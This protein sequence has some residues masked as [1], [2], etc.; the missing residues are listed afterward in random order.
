VLSPCSTAVFGLVCHIHIGRRPLPYILRTEPICRTFSVLNRLFSLPRHILR[1]RETVLHVVP[2]SKC[3][4]A[5]CR[6]FFVG[7]AYA[8][9][10]PLLPTLHKYWFLWTEF[11]TY[12]WRISTLHSAS[13]PWSGFCELSGSVVTLWTGKWKPHRALS[14]INLDCATGS[15]TAYNFTRVFEHQS[16]FNPAFAA[17]DATAHVPTAP[18]SPLVSTASATSYFLNC[19]RLTLQ[20]TSSHALSRDPSPS[21]SILT[22]GRPSQTPLAHSFLRQTRSSTT[23]SDDFNTVWASRTFSGRLPHRPFE[24]FRHI[25]TFGRLLSQPSRF[26]WQFIFVRSL[27]SSPDMVYYGSVLISVSV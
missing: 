22:F 8:A 6:M 25:L 19:P 13:T 14:W 16:I 1:S 23:L 21:G 3:T 7:N 24:H 10:S 5:C 4:Y 17:R 15:T 12:N 18:L 11:S 26:L 2:F 9:A 20:R 27:Q